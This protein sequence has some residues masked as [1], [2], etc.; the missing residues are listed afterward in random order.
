MKKKKVNKIL[1]DVIK[2]LKKKI[3]GRMS[4]RV[5][6]KLVGGT[7]SYSKIIFVHGSRDE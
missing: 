6:M 2:T 1:V 3:V 4:C 7:Q 5:K